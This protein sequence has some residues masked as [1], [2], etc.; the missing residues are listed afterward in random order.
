[1]LFAAFFLL[2]AKHEI[3]EINPPNLSKAHLGKKVI[4]Y[5]LGR[6]GSPQMK[7]EKVGDKVIAHNYGHGGA[8]W[9]LA[10]GGVEHVNTMFEKFTRGSVTKDTPITIIGAGCLG[11]FTAYD[12]VKRGYT[13]ITIIA[14]KFDNLASYEA[15]GLLA[16]I[17]MRNDPES[18]KKMDKIGIEGYRFY[19]NIAHGRDPIIRGGAI[20]CPAYF[21]SREESGLEPYVG[22]VMQPAKDVIVKFKKGAVREMVVYD[23]AIFIDTAK[24]MAFLADYLRDKVKVVKAEIYSF[25]EVKDKYIFNCAGLGAKTLYK[26]DAAA[27]VQGHLITLRNQNPEDLK[28][29]M[30]ASW[31]RGKQSLDKK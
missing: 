3:R 28:Y 31:G 16:P 27:A 25:A 5:C 13:N 17:F 20:I 8:G 26:D 1:M 30:L 19:A 29:M 21:D 7:V 11:L 6:S 23:D 4:F 18:Q 22:E 9:T 24:M 15:G 12:L 14:D 10:P 2:V